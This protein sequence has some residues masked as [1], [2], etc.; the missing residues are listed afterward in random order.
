MNLFSLKFEIND[1]FMFS[2][3]ISSYG[4]TSEVWRARKKPELLSTKYKDLILFLQIYLQC[5]W[6]RRL[7]L[8]QNTI[9]NINFY[10][11]NSLLFFFWI[12]THNSNLK[13]RGHNRKRVTW[14]AILKLFDVWHTENFTSWFD[15]CSW[16][17]LIR[18]S[19]HLRITSARSTASLRCSIDAYK[20]TKIT[21]FS[22]RGKPYRL[23]SCPCIMLVRFVQNKARRKQ[24]LQHHEWGVVSL[25]YVHYTSGQLRESS[26]SIKPNS[27]T[28]Q[29]LF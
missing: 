29:H 6:C 20:N 27:E 22:R 18:C 28:A 26:K 15:V 1:W 13:Y 8:L 10:V 17:S 25:F 3:R 11:T 4:C 2:V 5:C 16:S 14:E 7:R 19:S 21:Q 23:S 24:L 9:K 12:F